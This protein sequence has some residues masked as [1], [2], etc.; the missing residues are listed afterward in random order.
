MI[1]HFSDVVDRAF[2]EDF[3]LPVYVRLLARGFRPQSACAAAV[4]DG[5]P[6]CAAT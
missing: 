2:L 3:E 5:L 6:T 4:T 1:L